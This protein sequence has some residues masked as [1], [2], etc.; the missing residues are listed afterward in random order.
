MNDLP[1]H[2][3]TFLDSREWSPIVQKD[4]SWIVVSDLPFDKRTFLD[5][6]EW[7]PIA[8]KDIV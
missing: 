3:R 8:Q 6:R 7:Y 1:F 5:S 4:I 2:K